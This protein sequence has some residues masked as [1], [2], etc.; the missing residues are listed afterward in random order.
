[1]KK[2]CVIGSLNMDLTTSVDEF[3]K[4]GET[5]A[6]QNFKLH[7]GGK[8]ANQAIAAR[9]LGAEVQMIGLLG[10][11]DYG[12][13]YEKRL[14]KFGI[15]TSGIRTINGVSTGVAVI[16]VNKDGENTIV[17]VSGANGLADRSFIEKMGPMLLKNDLFL[18]QLEMPLSTVAY[19]AEFL[20]KNGKMVILDPAP[21][22]VF[23]DG[24]YKNISYITPNETEIEMLTGIKI[25]ETEDYER[26]GKILLEKGV[27]TVIIKAG[28]NGSF[29]V[30]AD[31]IKHVPSFS[32]EVKDTTAAGDS[33]NAGLAFSLANGCSVDDSVRFANAVGALA[34]TE[35]GAQ[36]AMPDYHCVKKFMEGQN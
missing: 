17:I 31:G 6:G 36:D 23:D 20:K 34:T 11:D 25:N 2:I 16:N 22:C 13:R 7:F 29:I 8:G 33:F 18:L 3:P 12:L 24:I 32:V 30:S 9:I 21:A 26:A 14:S 10:D 28:A 27:Q 5:V 1:M 4:P 35:Y 15:D 19:T